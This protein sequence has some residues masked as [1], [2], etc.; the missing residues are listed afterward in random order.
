MAPLFTD[1][2]L[3]EEMNM[4]NDWMKIHQS[5]LNAFANVPRPNFEAIAIIGCCEEHEEDFDVYRN[6]SWRE[7][8]LILQTRGFDP[9]DYAAIHP[10]AFHYFTP[11]VLSAEIKLLASVPEDEWGGL[12]DTWIG[13]YIINPDRIEEFKREY[14]TYFNTAQRQA[15]S[16]VLAWYKEWHLIHYGYDYD[17]LDEQEEERWGT[18]TE[19]NNLVW[20]VR[21][22]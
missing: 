20:N 11:G 18:I 12:I 5:L 1:T 9:S 13:H 15:V 21:D 2:S 8:E 16:E 17:E 22:A 14:L 6:I 4:I 3:L 19:A 10:V 7:F